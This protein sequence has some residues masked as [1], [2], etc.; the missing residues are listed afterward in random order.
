MNKII[1]IKRPALLILVLL[2]AFIGFTLQSEIMAAEKLMIPIGKSTAIPANGVKKIMAVK[3]GIVDV[4]NVSDE[5][6]I[7]SGLGPGETQ[8]ILWDMSG[9][10]VYDVETF[11]ENEIIQAKFTSIIT[12]K[13]IQLIIFPDSAYLKGQV[14]SEDEKTRAETVAKSLLGN[15]QLVSLV[16]FE[17]NTPSLQQRIEAA[18]K[19][20]TVQVSVVSPESDPTSEKNLLGTD[21]VDLRI[22]LHG[23]VNDQNDYIHLC[24]TVKGFVQDPKQISNL[25]TIE[26]PIQ[27]VFQAYILQVSKNNTDELGIEWGRMTTDN[28][29]ETGVLG[30]LENAG[31]TAGQAALPNYMNP[32][33]FKNINRFDLITAQVKAWETSGKAKVLANPK[34]MVYANAGAEKSEVLARKIS[35]AG[36]EK[37]DDANENETDIEKD[38]G[39][40]FVNV[41][42]DLYYPKSIDNQGN[43]TYDVAK[44]S[45]K[46]LIRDMFVNNNE[47]K[48]SVFAKQ[49]E[50]SFLRGNDG[51]PD[52][53]KRSIMTTLK[54]KDQQTVV[55]GGLINRQEGVSWKGVPVLS[56]IPYL[57]RLFRSKSVTNSENE[58]VILLTPKIANRETDLAG[59]SKYE[60]V[61]VPRRTD[62]LEKL[63]DI[64]QQIKSSHIPSDN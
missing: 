30:F 50:P 42:Q 41:G 60:T 37:L 33:Y 57:G 18:I 40:A 32:V 63:H 38:A 10:R 46:L 25:V 6:I 23:T 8:L 21:T 54:I 13:N 31:K 26:N 7:L 22:V 4:L 56:K 17:V 43:P 29:V 55:L 34:L 58:L 1:S 3:E 61:P 45:L 59:K 12:S 52:I 64:F 2:G 51:P 15:K 44:A 49:E 27:V 36:W 62:K 24:E 14:G 5:E 39:L 20:P 53:L 16:E 47:L 11:S 48:F 35:G 28:G 9:R 19:L